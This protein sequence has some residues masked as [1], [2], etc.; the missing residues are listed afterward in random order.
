MLSTPLSHG[1]FGLPRKHA[2]DSSIIGNHVS[3]LGHYTKQIAIQLPVVPSVRKWDLP[4][5]HNAEIS[6]SVQYDVWLKCSS[7]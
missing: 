1:T 2:G 5:A 4:V 6:T 7:T 3:R